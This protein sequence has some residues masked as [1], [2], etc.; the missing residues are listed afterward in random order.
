M[1][2]RG[3]F[4]ASVVNDVMTSDDC[5]L[6]EPATFGVRIMTAFGHWPHSLIGCHSQQS[7]NI[8]TDVS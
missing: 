4:F 2:V 7:V 5:M 3:S 1:R 8:S 6:T